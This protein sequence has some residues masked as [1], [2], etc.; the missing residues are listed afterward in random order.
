MAASHQS[1]EAKAPALIAAAALA[2]AAALS[3][4]NASAISGGGGEWKYCLA[5][6]HAV[7]V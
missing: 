4:L 1:P 5:T 3:P 7:E 6:M 2:A